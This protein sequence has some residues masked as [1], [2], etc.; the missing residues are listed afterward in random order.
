MDIQRRLVTAMLMSESKCEL[1]VSRR[2]QATTII[3]YEGIIRFIPDCDS[4]GK[5]WT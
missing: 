1:K 3:Q 2:I 5:T 4:M